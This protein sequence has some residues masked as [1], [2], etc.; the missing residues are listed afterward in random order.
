MSMKFI[1]NLTE[2]SDV[3][4]G[5]AYRAHF[6]TRHYSNE[7]FEVMRIPF[8]A[9]LENAV[10]KR[11]SEYLA[12]RY[13]AKLALRDWAVFGFEVTA[14]ENRCPVWPP[15][16]VGSISHTDSVAMC[17]VASSSTTGTL[18]I[19]IESWMGPD[20]R[21][22]VE[23]QIATRTELDRMLALE[24]VPRAVF[25][26]SVFGQGKHFQ[27]AVSLGQAVF[28]LHR[29]RARWRRQSSVPYD[30]PHN[31]GSRTP[32]CQ[33]AFGYR[34]LP[35]NRG[36]DHNVRQFASDRLGYGAMLAVGPMKIV[37][38]RRTTAGI[39]GLMALLRHAVSM[40]VFTYAPTSRRGANRHVTSRQTPV[41]ELW[42]K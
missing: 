29:G 1:S 28:R 35:D 8:P 34:Q 17:S 31:R 33:G 10:Q 23:G 13:L 26:F 24:F 30:L 2:D 22:S 18:G 27:S 14:D 36:Y 4:I 19:D 41:P 11:R 12:G 38:Q 40:V 21:S 9:A 15:G 16:L 32:D 7:L 6:H 3:R 39:E 5:I 37:M 42:Q 25:D 20:V